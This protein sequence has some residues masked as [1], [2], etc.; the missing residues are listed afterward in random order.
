MSQPGTEWVQF[1]FYLHEATFLLS[2]CISHRG[3][4]SQLPF[5]LNF[6]LSG[7][8]SVTSKFHNW[9]YLNRSRYL[10][11]WVSK[12]KTLK[13]PVLQI[14]LTAK[15]IC[16]HLFLWALFFFVNI[17][18]TLLRSRMLKKFF[19]PP[20]SPHPLHLFTKSSFHCVYHIFLRPLSNQIIFLDVVLSSGKRAFLI[21]NVRNS[22]LSLLFIFCFI[23][24]SCIRMAVLDI[25][26]KSSGTLK[27]AAIYRLERLTVFGWLG[28]WQL[29]LLI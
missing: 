1:N 12:A 3:E 26:K 21:V 17:P 6:P 20:T 24:W 19:F 23:K 13:H 16:P 27:A 2:F 15:C 29:F 9:I 10:N 14:F 22:W 5:S 11:S 8:K 7:E 4:P 25:S 28:I 18:A